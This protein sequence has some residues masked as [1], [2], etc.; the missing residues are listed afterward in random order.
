MKRVLSL[1]VATLLALTAL[2]AMAA[3]VV[4][5][6]DFFP[7]GTNLTSALPGV[8]LTALGSGWGGNDGQIYGVDPTNQTEPFTPAT[9]RLVFGTTDPS[10]PHLFMNSG[11]VEMRVDFAVPTNY[12]AIFF[13]SNDNSDVGMLRAYDSGGGLLATLTTASLGLNELQRLSVSMPGIAYAIMGGDSGSSSIGLDML[14]Y[15]K[16]P[17]P[18][19]VTL[20]LIGLIAGLALRRYR[21]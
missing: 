2:P 13:I 3:V 21:R 20:A 6:A 8:T 10:F 19:S 16:V 12:V 11:Y 5:D 15:D 1:L 7:L 17:E 4:V 9:G 14:L 18:G